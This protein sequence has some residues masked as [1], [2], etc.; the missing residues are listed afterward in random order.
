[1]QYRKFGKL[2]VE[3]SPLGFGMMRLPTVYDPVQ[4]K[5]VPDEK[6]AIENLRYAIDHGVNYVDSAYNYMG[7]QS[8]VIIGKAMK[9]GYRE[10]AY[11]ATKSPVM[12]YDSPE[13][14]DK[15]LNEQLTRLDMDCIDFYLFHGLKDTFLEKVIEY[16]AFDRMRQAKKDGKIKY[17]GFS[18]H[19]NLDSFKK[20]VDAFEWDFCQIQLN[21]FDSEYQ[22]GVEGLKYAAEKGLGV[23]IMEP[24]RGGFLAELPPEIKAVFKDTGKTPIETAFNWLWDK[25]EVTLTLS[26]MGAMEQVVENLGY[27]EKAQVGMLT[28]KDKAA[29]AEAKKMLQAIE[30]VPCTSCRYCAVCPNDVAIPEIFEAINTYYTKKSIGTPRKLYK[31]EAR[32]HG[33]DATACIGCR[34]CEN[35]CPQHILI[36]ELLPKIHEI[37]N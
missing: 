11:V 2:D 34:A 9:D 6:K 5:D 29:V 16:G 26:G 17:M 21:Y 37:L 1:M 18:F 4:E 23:V 35:V 3:V 27:A 22:A 20:I 28:E 14:F 24:L 7:G 8:E 12:F 19:D 15:L 33:N 31:I 25:P 13:S 32:K 30:T 10:K 36:S